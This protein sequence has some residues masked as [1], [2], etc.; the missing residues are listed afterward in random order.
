MSP[1]YRIKLS[2]RYKKDIRRLGKS[3]IDIS[4]LEL[5][6]DQLARGERLPVERKD[7]ELRGELRGTRECHIGPDWILRYMKD[8]NVLF[9]LL[10]S[11]GNHRRVL[12]IE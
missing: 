4:P 2:K 11:T 10:I 1:S 8:D 12:G 7:H 5:I 9:L 6:V 3:N